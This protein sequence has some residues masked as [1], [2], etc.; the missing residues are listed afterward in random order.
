MTDEP[1]AP[2]CRCDSP[3]CPTRHG[4]T[5][6]P[7]PREAAERWIESKYLI[8]GTARAKW[9][10]RREMIEAFSDGLQE[11]RRQERDRCLAL[12]REYSANMGLHPD[13]DREDMWE[14]LARLADEE[15]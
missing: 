14:L 15:G 12:V 3:D 1:R 6:H 7:A 11:G 9:Y 5:T 8:T 2:G 10:S 13:R 4:I